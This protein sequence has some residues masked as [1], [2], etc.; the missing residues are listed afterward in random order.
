M[1]LETTHKDDTVLYED[2]D[3]YEL[4]NLF[5]KDDAVLPEVETLYEPGDTRQER[6]DKVVAAVQDY[7]QCK[8]LIVEGQHRL[9]EDYQRALVDARHDDWERL[10]DMATKNQGGSLYC[11]TCLEARTTQI[12]FARIT[13]DQAKV[14]GTD[15]TRIKHSHYSTLILNRMKDMASDGTIYCSF[16]KVSRHWPFTM[17]RLPILITASALHGWRANFVMRGEYDGDEIH[18][19]S[20]A[21]PA[22]R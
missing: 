1:S 18:V 7:L 20:I 22:G 4:R 2:G 14:E 9:F 17:R 12:G 21:I 13:R 6:T 11:I 16:C 8:E 15:M 5:Y 10:R 19:D 3:E